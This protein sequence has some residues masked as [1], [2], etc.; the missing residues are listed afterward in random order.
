[1]EKKFNIKKTSKNSLEDLL[2]IRN[3]NLKFKYWEELETEDE[4]EAETKPKKTI[5]ICFE[6]YQK[7]KSE[8]FSELGP[9][10]NTIF[11]QFNF[12]PII[13]KLFPSLKKEKY[14]RIESLNHSWR[15]YNCEVNICVH[16][17][18]MDTFSKKILHVYVSFINKYLSHIF[19]ISKISDCLNVLNKKLKFKIYDFANETE[20]KE[21]YLNEENELKGNG[22]TFIFLKE[23][24]R[25]YD[26]LVYSQQCF[27][28]S[29]FYMFFHGIEK[30]SENIFYEY[31]IQNEVVSTLL[32]QIKLIFEKNSEDKDVI[33][34]IN[35]F[36]IEIKKDL[37]KD[38]YD[39]KIDD[40]YNHPEFGERVYQIFA[41]EYEAIDKDKLDT[42]PMKIN[43]VYKEVKDLEKDYKLNGDEIEIQE[44][45]KVKEIKDLDE[46][47]KYIQGDAKKKKKKKKKKEN[48]INKLEQFNIINKNV[49][50]DQMSIVSHDTIFS[51]FKKDIRSDNIE[52]ENLI[53]IKPNLSENFIEN[54]K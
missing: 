49:E 4:S 23:L 48:P 8:P 3:K 24:R 11:F 27:K 32:Y 35:N 26:C 12:S 29:I 17:T 1:M 53:K 14:E 28:M 40:I 18:R 15:H 22:C 43:Y 31:V 46:L 6:E 47:V 9:Y 16:K 33:N 38:D 20:E 37:K 2:D 44:D 54:L 10:M 42:I 19:G 51:N 13:N 5:R 36:T 25:L 50:D 45:E 52:D 21:I 41:Q 34:F 30:V 39:I 7:I